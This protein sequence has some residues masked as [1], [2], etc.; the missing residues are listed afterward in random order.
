[1]DPLPPPKFGHHLWIFPNKSG[2]FNFD[3]FVFWYSIKYRFIQYLTGNLSLVI[4]MSQEGLVVATL[5]ASLRMPWNDPS[6]YITMGFC[7]YTNGKHF[8]IV[9]SNLYMNFTWISLFWVNEPYKPKIKHLW[10]IHWGLAAGPI[11][12]K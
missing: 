12:L 1:M 8:S 5:L 3:L 10:Q 4:S 9:S 2:S 11:L 7:W 6:Y